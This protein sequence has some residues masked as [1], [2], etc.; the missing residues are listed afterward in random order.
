MP[1]LTQ[2]ERR[3]R[4]SLTDMKIEFHPSCLFLPVFLFVVFVLPE[5]TRFAKRHKIVQCSL[6]FTENA[7]F[8]PENGHEWR[9]S[10]ELFFLQEF[11]PS[12]PATQRL[13][14]LS[15]LSLPVERREFSPARRSEGEPAHSVRDERL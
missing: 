3:F 9:R 10:A 13:C 1:C 8:S 14:S 15:R 12:T 7:A 11:M 6:K 5:E 4:A 2:E